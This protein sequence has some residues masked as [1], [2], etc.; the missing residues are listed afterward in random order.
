MKKDDVRIQRH[1][2][3]SKAERLKIAQ[4]DNGPLELHFTKERVR[5]KNC[6]E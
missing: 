3:K 4:A 6:P 2:E 5:C 1:H